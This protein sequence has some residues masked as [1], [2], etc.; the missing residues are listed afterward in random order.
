MTE[1][2]KKPELQEITMSSF[3]E[4]LNK[5]APQIKDIREMLDHGIYDHSERNIF[6]TGTEQDKATPLGKEDKERIMNL[7]RTAPLKEFLAK[8]GA[9]TAAGLQGANYLIP[10]KVHDMLY[11]ATTAADIV[12][13]ISAVMLGPG[14]IPGTT[15]NVDIVKDINSTTG[16]L[17]P[18]KFSSGGKIAEANL[19]TTQATLDFSNAFGVRFGIANDLIE[20][21]KWDL[22]SRSISEAGK[23]LGE[24]ATNMACTVLSAPPDGD[25]TLNAG[26]TGTDN[27]TQWY[28]PGATLY[29]VTAGIRDNFADGFNSDTMVTTH[30]AMLGSIMET[31]GGVYNES[32]VW[33]EYLHGGYP[34]KIGPLSIFYADVDVMTN[35]KAFSNCLTCVFQKQYAIMSGRKRWLRLENYSDPIRDLV[36]AVISCR[37]D[38]ISIYKDAICTIT[39]T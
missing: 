39:E 8:S 13:D 16:G 23:E 2:T 7:I 17:W 6:G 21:Q 24:Y 3:Q 10:V 30:E 34:T 1:E 15:Y 38:S 14:D 22:V 27:T 26:T 19:E 37:Q 20:D 11:V 36:G 28:Y 18:R 9:I 25:G 35:T 31:T 4:T 33:N 12:P 29:D 32:S 5:A